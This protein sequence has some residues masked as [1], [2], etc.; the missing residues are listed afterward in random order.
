MACD[1][2]LRRPRLI[3]GSGLPTRTAGGRV[4]VRV[5]RW[6]CLVKVAARSM[7]RYQQEERRS[8]KGFRNADGLVLILACLPALTFEFCAP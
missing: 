4:E 8:C 7:G 3:L 1:Y 5:A 6:P 2:P